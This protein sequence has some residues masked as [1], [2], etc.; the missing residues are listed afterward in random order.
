MKT[1]S[2]ILKDIQHKLNMNYYIL[3]PN[4]INTNW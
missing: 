4:E 2:K 1:T 3:A